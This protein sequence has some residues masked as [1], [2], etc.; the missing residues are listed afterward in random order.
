MDIESLL[1]E[2]VINN[3]TRHVHGKFWWQIKPEFLQEA[4]RETGI[5]QDDYH[6]LHIAKEEEYAMPT[7]S[8]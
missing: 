3:L 4:L 2:W 1:H 7:G 6:K 8:E 5:S